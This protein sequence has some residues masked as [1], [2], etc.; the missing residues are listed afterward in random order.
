MSRDTW[1]RQ[2]RVA[3]NDA[4]VVA[5]VLAGGVLDDGL[6]HAGRAVLRCSSSTELIASATTVIQSLSQ[7]AGAE[8]PN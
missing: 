7:R 4:S 1:S 2:L 8:I 5:R 6:Q 3:G